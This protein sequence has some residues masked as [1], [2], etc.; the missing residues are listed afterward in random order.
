MEY[1]ASTLSCSAYSHSLDSNAAPSAVVELVM[2][3]DG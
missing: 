2:V 1:M 3:Y